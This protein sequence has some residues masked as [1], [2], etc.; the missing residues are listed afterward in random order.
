MTY[1]RPDESSALRDLTLHTQNLIFTGNPFDTFTWA[2]ILLLRCHEI[3]QFYTTIFT[4]ILRGGRVIS[5]PD[6][7]RFMGLSKTTPG[8]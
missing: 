6:S 2:G 8:P 3:T 1:T 7:L 4:L 5:C